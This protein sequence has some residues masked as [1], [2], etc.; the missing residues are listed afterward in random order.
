MR[1][2]GLEG[3]DWEG[4]PRGGATYILHVGIKS[5]HTWHRSQQFG[6]L[7]EN[8]EDCRSNGGNTWKTDGID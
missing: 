2:P 1:G 5:T 7:V 4:T 3:K 6:S 8:I